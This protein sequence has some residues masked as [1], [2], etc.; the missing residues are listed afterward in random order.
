MSSGSTNVAIGDTFGALF[1][2]A[3]IAMGIYGITTLQ[4]YFYYMSFPKDDIPTKL[5]V[6]AIWILDTIHVVFMCHAVHYYLIVGFGNPQALVS[7]TWWVNSSLF[8]GIAHVA[9]ISILRT[10][11][12]S[13][14]RTQYSATWLTLF[15]QASIGVNVV[16]SFIAQCF[17]TERIFQLCPTRHRWW[18]TGI[19]GI[20]VLAH[21]VFGIETVAFLFI[22]KEFRRLKEVSLVA[23]VPFGI[24]AIVS[25]ILIAAT[26]CILLGRNRSAFEDTNNIINGLIIFA[27]N[28]CILTSAV[29][30]AETIVFSI[31]PNSF[32]SLAIDFVIGKLYANSLLAVLNSRATLRSDSRGASD[33]TELSTSF[34]VTSAV[35]N[36]QNV[37]SQVRTRENNRVLGTDKDSR[38]LIA[39]DSTPPTLK[40]SELNM[41]V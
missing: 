22:K 23:A 15:C 32:Y 39:T 14:R 6:A 38:H 16:V 27:I 21:F 4:A 20:T 19:I 11:F 1:I 9:R 7:G 5:L 29:A 30:V 13:F 33:S 25:D 40:N 31:L 18:V 10:L 2:A 35:E 8:L 37:L 17:F 41:Q 24:V 28:R 36:H 12:V 26:L 34:H 3:L